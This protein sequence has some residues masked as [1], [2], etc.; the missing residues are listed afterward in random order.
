MNIPE[1][2]FN[3]YSIKTYAREEWRHN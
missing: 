2:T 3:F 1:K